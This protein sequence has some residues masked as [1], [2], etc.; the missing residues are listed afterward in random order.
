MELDPNYYGVGHLDLGSEPCRPRCGD[1]GKCGV[2]HGILLPIRS[3][4]DGTRRLL[5]SNFLSSACYRRCNR[6]ILGASGCRI[7]EASLNGATNV[8][9]SACR[10]LFILEIGAIRS[11]IK[12]CGCC[13]E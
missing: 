1:N 2:I 11:K 12:F 7:V 4:T 9:C 3:S 13:A 5:F 10:G 8:C 6:V